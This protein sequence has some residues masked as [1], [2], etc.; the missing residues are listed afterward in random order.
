MI[1]MANYNVIYADIF[2]AMNI[3][4]SSRFTHQINRVILLSIENQQLAEKF[5]L[6]R[7]A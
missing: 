7:K 2:F 4:T 6:K 5:K 1:I 3:M